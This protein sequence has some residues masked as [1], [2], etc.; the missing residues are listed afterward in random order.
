MYDCHVCTNLIRG[1][2]WG[3]FE[4]QIVRL[5]DSTV[6]A[7]S[8]GALQ[9]PWGAFEAHPRIPLDQIEAHNV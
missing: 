1:A 6:L 2:L 7:S 9:M 4:A 3:A 8:A 5:L